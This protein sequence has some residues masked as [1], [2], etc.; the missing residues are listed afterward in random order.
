M[1]L[2]KNV[3]GIKK[4][5][6]PFENGLFGVNAEITRR[7]FFGGLSAEMLNNRKFF[8]GSD[9]PSGWECK[10]FEYIKDKPGLSLCGS[11]FVHLKDG[12]V[13]QTSPVIALKKGTVYTARVWIKALGAV[14]V[15]FGVAGYE[16]SFD[17][18]ADGE[19]Y[20]EFSFDFS[21]GRVSNG[22]FGVSVKGSAY[23]FEASLMIKDNF[24]GMRRDVIAALKRIRPS[25][26]RFPGGCAADHFDWKESLKAP[27]FRRPA[28]AGDKWFLFRDTYDQDCL[29]VGVNEFMMMC[30]EIGAEPEYTLSLILSDYEDAR[31]LVEYCG[32]GPDT[33]YGAKRQALGF[34]RFGVRLWYIGNEVYFFGGKY[35]DDPVLAAKK[36]DEL[37]KA[38]K[39]ADPCAAVV[40]GLTWPESFKQ[41][42]RDFVS[43]LGCGYEFVSYHNYIGI[44]P[45]P[46]QG[47]NGH[48]TAAMLESNFAD[49]TDAGLDFYKD[50]LY[51]DGFGG[52]DVCADEWN[53]SWGRDSSNALFFSNALQFHFFAKS[54]EKYHVRRAQ[55]FMPV[56]E[57][58]ITVNGTSVRTEST[59]RMFRLMQGHK[60]GTVMGCAAD[61]SLDVLCTAHGE[62]IFVS[63]VNRG[64]EPA[65]ISVKGYEITSAVQI[66]TEGYGFDKNDFRVIRGDTVLRGH[67]VMFIKAK[68]G[69][70]NEEPTA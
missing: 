47:E 30:R 49:G 33:E 31:R 66:A 51:K 41:W 69:K 2:K 18:D 42:N 28:Q 37:I 52:I 57:G 60:N 50:D 35:K 21:C 5:E 1:T 64:S 20:K 36:T 40:I 62:R 54:G 55:F 56:N 8:A 24:Y 19:P 9:S 4:P 13:S 59:G 46:T 65:D 3:I 7:G 38:V 63:A 12:A 53:Y 11:A 70:K 23:V 48:A 45:D 34:D 15:S 61:P 68:K 6:Y 43:A 25:S 67:S 27:E 17:T 44:L 29:D 22:T 16:K 26:V 58:M 14:T 10:G 32:G 39:D